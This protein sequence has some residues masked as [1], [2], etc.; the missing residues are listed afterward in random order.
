MDNLSQS[1]A[2]RVNDD[3]QQQQ[4]HMNKDIYVGY[5]F[6]I[7]WRAYIHFKI[8]GQLTFRLRLGNK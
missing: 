6:K 1:N 3:E 4:Q 5:I 2:I 8:K 7:P